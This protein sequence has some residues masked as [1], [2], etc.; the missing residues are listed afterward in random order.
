MFLSEKH[1]NILDE[2]DTEDLDFEYICNCLELSEEEIDTLLNDKESIQILFDK[3]RIHIY[4]FDMRDDLPFNEENAMKCIEAIYKHEL[5]QSPN[6]LRTLED[7][8]L[9]FIEYYRYEASDYL[10]DKF[11]K[12]GN[13]R[14]NLLN[15]LY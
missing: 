12:F 10:K 2:Y 1:L 8:T 13:K 5:D 7:F 6:I 15:L 11:Q 3:Y 9:S 4:L 14:P